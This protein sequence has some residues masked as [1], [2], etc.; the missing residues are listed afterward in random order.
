MVLLS[1]LEIKLPRARLYSRLGRS[2]KARELA[3]AIASRTHSEATRSEAQQL[4]GAAP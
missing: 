1:S 3:L 4:L 2:L